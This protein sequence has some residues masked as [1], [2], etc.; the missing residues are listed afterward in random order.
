MHLLLAVVAGGVG[1]ALWG[2]V[3]S[4]LRAYRDVNEIVTTLMMNYV[5]IYFVSY[6]VHYGPLAEEGAFFPQSPP[7][8]PSSHLPIL[9]RGTSLHAGIIMGLVCG[10]FLHFLLRYTPFGFRTRMVG[11]N[12]EAARY[13]GVK[14]ARQIFL[15]ML[16]SSGLGGLAG[17]GEVLGLK[18][19]L[20]DF[21]ASGV[22]YDAIAVAL[23]ANGN[24]LGVILSAT[25][26]GA[27]KAGANRMQIVVGIETHVA[28]VVQALALLF[29]IAIG[30]AER[31][32]LTRRKRKEEPA[33][34][35]V[36]ANGEEAEATQ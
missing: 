28:T 17:V 26:F 32:R 24:P 2:L 22:G 36:L 10:I 13:A 25:F 11:A 7:L 27:L 19:R 33:I 31:V 8:L 30:F 15:V 12:P 1:G 21:F 3:P 18:L 23:M 20:F 16:V 4:Y 5:G 35:K 9:I 29:V 34:E 14:V 6:L